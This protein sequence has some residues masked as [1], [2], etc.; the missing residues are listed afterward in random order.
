LASFRQNA[1]DSRRAAGNW[2]RFAKIAFLE[3]PA[4]NVTKRS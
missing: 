1:L 3:P 4:T 2:L